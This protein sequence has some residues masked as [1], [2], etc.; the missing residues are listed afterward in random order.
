VNEADI[1]LSGSNGI[2]RFPQRE[3]SGDVTVF[4]T[5]KGKA[6]HYILVANSEIP[7]TND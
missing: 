7:P 2:Q 1:V 3:I 6:V 4:P 5:K